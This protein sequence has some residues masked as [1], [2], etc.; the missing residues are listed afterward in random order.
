VPWV[1]PIVGVDVE[2]KREIDA[3]PGIETYS[4][5]QYTVSVLF[6]PRSLLYTFSYSEEI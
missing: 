1:S 2:V 4:H 6:V 5:S 3:L